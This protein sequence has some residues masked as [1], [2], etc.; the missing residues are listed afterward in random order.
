[1]MT[2]EERL[3]VLEERSATAQETDKALLRAIRELK[4]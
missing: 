4:L 3:E 1:M 2:T